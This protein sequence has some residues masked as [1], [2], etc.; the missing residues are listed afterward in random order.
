M[1]FL[2]GSQ[3]SEKSTNGGKKNLPKA[4]K[5]GRAREIAED[6]SSQNTDNIDEFSTENF[7][8]STDNIQDDSTE[9]DEWE[10][11]QYSTENDKDDEDFM[12]DT[13]VKGVDDS[14][15]KDGDEW[16][17]WVSDDLDQF[18]DHLSQVYH[19]FYDDIKKQNM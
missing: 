18:T 16:D 7:D 5:G 19:I 17:D 3:I 9:K 10:I 6:W 14:E 15:V 4:Q 1:L 8:D 11:G 12:D 13:V 2:L